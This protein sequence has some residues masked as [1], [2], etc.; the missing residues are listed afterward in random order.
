MSTPNPDEISESASAADTPAKTQ[1]DFFLRAGEKVRT[2]FP[3]TPGV[4]L[5]QDQAGRVLYVG[6]AVNLKARAGSYFLKAA[7]QDHRTA[8]LVQE[9]Y[10][11]DY[12]DAESEVDALLMES[13]LI[14]DIQPKHNK[15]LR[16]DKTFPYL[17]ITTHEDFPRVEI[18]R[19]PRST[20]VKLY[21]PFT[22]IGSLHSAHASTATSLSVSHLFARYQRGG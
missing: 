11:I 2:K 19:E 8:R 7:A 9:V 14:K 6:K 21:G 13:R 1:A 4:Y 3:T 22:S 5:F 12:L 16:D 18:T 15:E 10:D 17:Q 20:G